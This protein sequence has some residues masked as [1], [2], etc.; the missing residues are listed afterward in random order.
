MRSRCFIPMVDELSRRIAPS[1]GTT[2]AVMSSATSDDS[3]GP[4]SR[5]MRSRR[6]IPMVDEL[7]RR[8][9]PSGGVTSSMVT[10]DSMAPYTV[11]IA[12][13]VRGSFEE[14]A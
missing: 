11:A 10:M 5:T 4:R 6:F 2:S 8:I 14:Y 3:G 12:V 9:A 13:P 1:G 7:S